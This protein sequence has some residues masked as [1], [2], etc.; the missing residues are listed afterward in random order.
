MFGGCRVNFWISDWEISY[1]EDDSF[2]DPLHTKHLAFC[3][4]CLALLKVRELWVELVGQLQGY[5]FIY[6]HKRMVLTK[7]DWTVITLLIC[8]C[9]LV[10]QDHS[11]LLFTNNLWFLI[12]VKW[13]IMQVDLVFSVI[14]KQD[15]SHIIVHK[16]PWPKLNYFWH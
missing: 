6:K 10:S 1:W 2:L 15:Y 13:G 11:S 12:H 9:C 14:S 7:E 3:V 4:D 16:Y 8:I 5:K